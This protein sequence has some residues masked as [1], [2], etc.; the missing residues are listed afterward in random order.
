MLKKIC[1]EKEFEKI[2]LEKCNLRLKKHFRA[3]S[4]SPQPSGANL[5]CFTSNKLRFHERKG[6]MVKLSN[7]QVSSR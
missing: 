3:S 4:I 2:M 5:S 7:N 6:K 1:D